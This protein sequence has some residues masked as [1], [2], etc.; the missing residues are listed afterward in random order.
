MPC[1]LLSP[2]AFLLHSSQRLDDH[3]RIYRDHT[4]W[5]Q[6]GRKLLDIDYDKSFL[7]RLTVFRA[8]TAEQSLKAFSA[9]LTSGSNANLTPLQKI[10]MRWHSKLGHLGFHHVLKLALGGYLDKF[11]LSLDRNTTPPTCKACLYGK[12]VRRHH[13][14]T[15]TVKN[16]HMIGNLKAGQLKPG[17]RIFCDQLESRIRGRRLHT[18]GRE[19]D[20]DKFCGSTVFCDA[21][22]NYL[23]V[24]HQVTL[25]A[26]ETINSKT[27]FERKAREMGVTVDE[28]HTD[29]GIFKSKEFM[30]EIATNY[31]N[32]RFSGV[33]AKWQNGAAEGAISIVTSKART[34]MLHAAIHWPELED[35]SLWP[36]AVDYATYLYNHTPNPDSG[37]SPA[38]IF[39]Q[40]LSDHS[41]LRNAHIWGCPVYVLEPRLSQVGAKIPKWQPRSR[42]AQFVGMS[43]VH[44]ENIG[45]VRNLNTGYIS[46]QFHV[47]YDDW[48]ETVYAPDG[49]P[50]PQW[51][52]LCIYSCY[53]VQFEPGATPPGLQD[54]WYSKDELPQVPHDA[55]VE[56]RRQVSQDVYNKDSRDDKYFQPPNS[57]QTREPPAPPSPL[58]PVSSPVPPQQQQNHQPSPVPIKKEPTPPSKPEPRRSQRVRKTLDGK[59][60]TVH[61]DKRQTYEEPKPSANL[62][63]HLAASG[64]Q[65]L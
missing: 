63:A 29:N 54:E 47:V 25:S 35:K 52:E 61:W 60:L 3:F 20:R 17:E 5:H 33:G 7:P 27:S 21:A 45:M 14:A 31:Q 58:T 26:S 12:Q 16:P 64:T 13:E 55:P 28:Y 1:R 37:V 39:S 15:T 59:R 8:G 56:G 24:E 46:P 41:A 51:D 48:F 4:E 2:Q 10:W 50:P 65:S 38:E 23:H 43:P 32:I 11:A 36:L 6:F 9:H 62:A 30:E 40:T 18:A 34:M 22:S 19:P 57:P 53:E 44:A 42:R 49:P